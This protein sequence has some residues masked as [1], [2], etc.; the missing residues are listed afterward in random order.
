MICGTSFVH[1]D[2]IG[3]CCTICQ[4]ILW[5]YCLACIWLDCQR[6]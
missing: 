2:I 4:Y 3:C 1:I 6:L 5:F